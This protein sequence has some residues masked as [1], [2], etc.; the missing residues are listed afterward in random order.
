MWFSDH[1]TLEYLALRK[2][3]VKPSLSGQRYSSLIVSVTAILRIRFA[4]V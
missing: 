4:G 2:T 3:T 1:I